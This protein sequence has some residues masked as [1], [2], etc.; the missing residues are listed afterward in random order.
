MRFHKIKAILFDVGGTLIHT[1]EPLI[2]AISMAFEQNKLKIPRSEEIIVQ[3]GKSA[4]K[5]IRVILSKELS[6]FEEKA[7]ECILSFQEIF[8]NKVLDEFKAIDG[9]QKT[10]KTLKDANYRL[11][12]ITAL[13]RAELDKLLAKFDL[14]PYFEVFV[15]ADDVQ[16]IRP[17]PEIVNMAM[18]LLNVQPK[19]VVCVGDT[20]NDILASKN[21]GT[22][23]IA[24]LTGAQSENVLKNEL[25]DYIINDIT[26]LP[27]LLNKF[28]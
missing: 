5:I 8:P 25:P 24:V 22:Y 1:I 4:T 19:E 21:A 2:A 13:R 27:S 28:D 12:V 11:G 6:N 18:S 23:S 17:S 14:N 9:V 7:K 10:L 20:V 16:N 15:T 3:L 26:A